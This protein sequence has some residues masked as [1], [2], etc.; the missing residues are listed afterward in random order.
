M[1]ASTLNE[2]EIARNLADTIEIA[3]TVVRADRRRK[4]AEN[5]RVL[6]SAK[7]AARLIDAGVEA[8]SEA[9]DAAM[10]RVRFNV[11]C[12]MRLSVR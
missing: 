7:T 10:K 4:N 2:I 3:F 5:T 11:L 12:G 9:L 6:D 1:N 8:D